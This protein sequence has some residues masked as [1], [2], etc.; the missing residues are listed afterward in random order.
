METARR[1]PNVAW[2]HFRVW[3]GRFQRP[4]GWYKARA[5]AVSEGINN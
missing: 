2:Q 3:H 5:A 1:A 4:T